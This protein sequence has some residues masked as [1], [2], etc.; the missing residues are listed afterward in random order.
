MGDAGATAL[1][2]LRA[3]QTLAIDSLT[4]RITEL[5]D[6]NG[7][8]SIL[9]KGP[10]VANW[11]YRDQPARAYGDS[12][13]LVSPENWEKAHALL[14][15]IGFADAL[16]P[17]AHP[18]MESIT[19]HSWVRGEQNVDLHCSIW[20]IG[21]EPAKVWEVLRPRTVPMEVG[22][23]EV[24]VLAPAPRALHLGLHAAQH[25]AEAGKTRWDLELAIAQ[26]PEEV[27][28]EAARIAADLDA[29]AAF[30]TGLAVT[31]EG[32]VLADRLGIAGARSVEAL[33][34][35]APVPMALGFNQLA[36]A[37]GLRAKLAIVAEELFPTPSFMRW[38]SP[39]ARRGRLGLAVAYLWRPV[40]LA[41]RAGPGFLT[42]RKARKAEADASAVGQGA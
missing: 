29:T 10:A 32:A 28:G 39:L 8:E 35:V 24:R 1:G 34:T 41:L 3:A 2:R 4:A 11:L 9:L 18:R 20:G 19:S 21:A 22:G 38:W 42:W 13:L 27:W 5:F 14:R 7:V 30:A 16:G 15:G 36:N 33:L 37:P 26:L 12:D 40:W 25:T 31:R 17:L 6:D 23:R